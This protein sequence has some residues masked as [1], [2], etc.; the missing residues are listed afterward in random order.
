MADSLIKD[1]APLLCPVFATATLD[2]TIAPEGVLNSV[3]I[4]GYVIGLAVVKAY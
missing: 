4:G 2:D 1:N 3:T